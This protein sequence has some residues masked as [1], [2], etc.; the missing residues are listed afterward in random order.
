MSNK[1]PGDVSPEGIE[2]F[3]ADRSIDAFCITDISRITAPEDR[4]PH[5][6]L[7]SCRTIILFGIPLTDRFYFGTP[8]ERGAETRHILAALESTANA[9]RDLL[10]QAGSATEVILPLPLTIR[11]GQVRGRLSLKYCAEDAGFGT[12]GENTLLINPVYGNRL[13]LAA[14]ITGREIASSIRP[15]SLPACIHCHRCVEACPAGAIRNGVVDMTACRSF[16]S[17]IPRFVRPLALRLMRGRWSARI[18]TSVLNLAAP[19]L[20]TRIDIP[21]TCSACVTACPYF[22]KGKR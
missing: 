17:H 10:V 7:P 6:I 18:L 2:R 5:R 15:A 4:H 20:I 9:L 3:F 22:Q 13:V 19:Y 16:A 14:V 1:P 21:V 11:D 8:K 12:I